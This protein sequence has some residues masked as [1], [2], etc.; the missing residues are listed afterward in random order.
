MSTPE[1]VDCV[2]VEPVDRFKHAV[3]AAIDVAVKQGF[4]VPTD[5]Q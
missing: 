2:V 5:R 3:L 4:A 1:R